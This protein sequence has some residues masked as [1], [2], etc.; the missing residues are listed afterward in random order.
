MNSKKNE[1]DGNSRAFSKK[2]LLIFNCSI[3]RIS[4]EE[5]LLLLDFMMS[6]NEILVGSIVT[7]VSDTK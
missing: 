3:D 1:D 2:L 4:R 7:S 5:M 6:I